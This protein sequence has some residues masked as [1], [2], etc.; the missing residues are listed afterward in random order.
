MAKDGFGWLVNVVEEEPDFP[1]VKIWAI[2]PGGLL[3]GKLVSEK[4]FAEYGSEL[5]N[6]EG[7]TI[8]EGILRA[9]M[10]MHAAEMMEKYEAIISN[11]HVE[12][13]LID[14]QLF[15]GGVVMRPKR[16]RLRISDVSAWGMGAIPD[17]L[18]RPPKTERAPVA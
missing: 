11:D 18:A 16:L 10:S 6:V 8:E 15:S 1:E 5:K 13:C 9:E 4:R 14:A 2:V 3:F 12:A 17:G 7:V